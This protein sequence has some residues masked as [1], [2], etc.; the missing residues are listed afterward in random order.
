L[1]KHDCGGGSGADAGIGLDELWYRYTFGKR[2]AQTGGG[3]VYS[4]TISPMTAITSL[5]YNVLF[6]IAYS[7][8]SDDD[9]WPGIGSARRPPRASEV[10]ET[11]RPGRRP[12]ARVVGIYNIA[13]RR[14]NIGTA[15]VVGCVPHRLSRRTRERPVQFSDYDRAGAP[16]YRS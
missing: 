12:R 16:A 14:N 4:N 13:T 15:A 1:I 11:F 10:D 3:G 9:V 2:F 7:T 5:H 8:V 6:I